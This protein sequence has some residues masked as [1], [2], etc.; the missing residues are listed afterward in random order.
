MTTDEEQ[1]LLR[2]MLVMG[3][4]GLD[5]TV[6]QL[7]RNGL[8]VLI[9]TDEVVRKGLLTFVERRI[10][11]KEEEPS[12]DGAAKFLARILAADSQQSQ[13]IEEYI[14]DLTGASLQSPEELIKASRALGVSAKSAGIRKDELQPIFDVRNKIIHELDMNL[15]ARRRNRNTRRQS[16]MTNYVDCLM[17]VGKSLLAQVAKR[18][19]GS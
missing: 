16:D 10:K 12:G 7:I 9:Q 15:E 13:V 19:L 2:A 3:A 4:A 8:P 18:V 1:D 14:K 5:G 6:K 17:G 11:R